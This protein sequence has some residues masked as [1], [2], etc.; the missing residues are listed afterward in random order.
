MSARELVGS[1]KVSSSSRIKRLGGLFAKYCSTPWVRFLPGFSPRW[2][3]IRFTSSIPVV[4]ELQA[5][6]NLF[7]IYLV[8]ISGWCKTAL[9]RDVYPMPPAP[10]IA[11][12][13][14]PVLKK[15]RMSK[16]SDSRPWKILGSDGSIEIELEL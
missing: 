16:S 13:G 4:V 11:I 14:I 8:V 10:K 5:T 9:A 3:P 7:C 1:H 2:L 15:W 6:K 12:L